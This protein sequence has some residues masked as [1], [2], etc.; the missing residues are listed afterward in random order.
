MHTVAYTQVAAW[1]AAMR[2][3]ATYMPRSCLHHACQPEHAESAHQE[4]L[5][6]LRGR[7]P[8]MDQQ[9]IPGPI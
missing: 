1:R 3:L 6:Q 5:P 8:A 2:S 7:D 4:L 9:G